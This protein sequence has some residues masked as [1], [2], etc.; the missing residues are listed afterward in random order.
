MSKSEYRMKPEIRTNGK[1]HSGFGLRDSD[2]FR[3]SAFGFRISS[4]LSRA[5]DFCLLLAMTLV[6]AGCQWRRSL[7][8]S[9]APG[10]TRAAVGQIAPNVYYT[11]ANQLLTPVGVQVE[12]PG[13]RPQGIAV[14]PNGRMIVTSGKTHE[15][16]VIEPRTGRILQQV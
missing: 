12:L 15:L 16:I 14:S 10:S 8:A 2:L 13:M 9:A 3:I 7:T 1:G 4:N 5:T 6:I 11:P